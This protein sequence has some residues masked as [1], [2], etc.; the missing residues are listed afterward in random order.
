MG[1]KPAENAPTFFP[2][3]AKFRAWLRKNHKKEQVLLVGYYKKATGKPSITWEESV[4][5]ALCYGWIDGVRRSFS[6]EAYVIRFSPRKPKSVWSRRNIER[7]EALIAERRM[8]KAGMNAYAHKD[9]H[10]DSG[11]AVGDLPE[12]LPKKMIAEFKKHPEA[13]AFYESQPA[14][15]RKQTAAWV[16]SAKRA[17]TRAR[18]L[19]TL[20]ADSEQ[21]LRIKQLRR[22]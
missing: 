17:E 15:Y 12:K 2:T 22:N 4:D 6:D 11:Y 10:A 19:A 8:R 13:W 5:E 18:R 1:S 14:G 7:V 16:S 21:G 9:V 20:I 3:P